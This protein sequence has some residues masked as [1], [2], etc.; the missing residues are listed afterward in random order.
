MQTKEGGGMRTK[1][2]GYGGI[3]GLEELSKEEI[4]ARNLETYGSK[5]K[6]YRTRAGL[7]VDSWPAS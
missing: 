4:K 5:V 6:K 1:A 2:K 7:S 3:A